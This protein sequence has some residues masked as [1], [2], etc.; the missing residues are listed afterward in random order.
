V[1]VKAA[2]EAEVVKAIIEE[3]EEDAKCR[4][5]TLHNL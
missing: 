2:V 4:A 1:E 5:S 3:E